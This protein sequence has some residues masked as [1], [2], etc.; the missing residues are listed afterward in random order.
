MVTSPL[1]RK[2]GSCWRNTCV[3]VGDKMVH[4]GQARVWYMWWGARAWGMLL[5]AAAPP[6]TPLFLL[7]KQ[8][9]QYN[10]HH[11]FQAAKEC[12]MFCGGAGRDTWQGG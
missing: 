3:A 5:F 12:L 6:L 4:V 8:E 1:I 10:V 7:F 2:R 9:L 11:L